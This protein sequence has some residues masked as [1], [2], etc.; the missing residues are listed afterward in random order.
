M[1]CGNAAVVE[2]KKHVSHNSLENL[3]KVYHIPTNPAIFK[4]ILIIDAVLMAAQPIRPKN[5]RG[6]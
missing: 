1:V 3:F 6:W 4:S 2:N 5:D